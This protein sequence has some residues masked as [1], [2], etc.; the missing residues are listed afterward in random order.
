MPPRRARRRARARGE[1]PSEPC[2]A[3]RTL[4]PVRWRRGD[5]ILLRSLHRDRVLG[6]R[7]VTVADDDGEWTAAWLASGTPIVEPTLADGRPIRSVPVAERYAP[8]RRWRQRDW[9]G[10][11]VLKLVPR[12]GAHSIWL[13]WGD[14]GAF[15]GW[16]VNLEAAHRRWPDGIDSEDHALDIW[17]E[18]GGSWRWKDEDE[19]DVAARAGWLDANEVRAEG[20]RVLAAWPFPTGWEDFRPDPAWPRPELPEDWD[21]A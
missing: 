8:D 9:R 15:R 20:E 7:P 3:Q 5:R 21:V 13:F 12:G 14:D 19:L 18:A 4:G 16:Y 2:G 10:H 17:V 6:A 1:R 11:G